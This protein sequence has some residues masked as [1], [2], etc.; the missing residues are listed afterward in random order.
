M[1]ILIVSAIDP[2]AIERLRQRHHVLCEFGAKDDTLRTLVKDCEALVFRSGVRITAEVMELAPNLKLLI[3][4]GSGID[5]LDVEYAKRRG[6]KLVRIPEPGAKAV[7]ELS[8]AFMLALSRNL[9]TADRLTRQGRW[10][11]NELAGQ[12]LLGKT[13][14]VVGVGNIGTRVSEVGVAWGMLVVGCVEHPSAARAD[15]MKKM[16]IHITDLTEVVSTADYVSIHVPLKDSTRNL[17]NA[18]V[19]SQMKQGSFLINLARGGVVDEQALY[20]ALTEGNKLRGAALDVH[21]QE[22]E[23]KISPLADLPNVILTPHIG[24]SAIDTQ[25]EIGDRIIETVDSFVI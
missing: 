12:L 3:R 10:A 16:G 23:G 18:D 14:G 4:A 7:A 2:N 13:L 11:K 19:L 25:R 1:K 6:L 20:Q 15:D 17:I 21:T 24:S 22:G 8:F 5:N 9:I